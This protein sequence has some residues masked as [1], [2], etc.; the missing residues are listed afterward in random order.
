[1]PEVRMFLVMMYYFT[2]FGSSFWV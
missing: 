2:Y 1:M